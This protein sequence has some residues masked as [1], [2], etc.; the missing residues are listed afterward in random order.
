MIFEF[1][2]VCVCVYNILRLKEEI[3]IDLNIY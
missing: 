1:M 3:E 2:H